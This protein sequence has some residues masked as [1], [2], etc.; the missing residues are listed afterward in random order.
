MDK[1]VRAFI[2]PW[3]SLATLDTR[4]LSWRLTCIFATTILLPDLIVTLWNHKKNNV[5]QPPNMLYILHTYVFQNITDKYLD[6]LHPTIY[7]K[8]TFLCF[9][10]LRCFPELS[11][12]LR[13]SS[14]KV[15]PSAFSQVGYIDLTGTL[16]Q[17]MLVFLYD[18]EN[19]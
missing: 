12:S 7:K 19:H 9:N 16:D 10:W 4:S 6:I 11:Q 18:H 2:L 17:K 13:L 15:L 3:F 14:W 5:L 8:S 1:V